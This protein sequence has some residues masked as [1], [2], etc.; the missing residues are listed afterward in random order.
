MTMWNPLGK[1][2]GTPL[3]LLI[4]LAASSGFILVSTFSTARHI[5]GWPLTWS[6][7]IAVWL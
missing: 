4:T 1:V 3:L 6:L 2:E 7:V 5:Y